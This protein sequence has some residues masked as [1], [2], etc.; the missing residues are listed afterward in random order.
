M[1]TLHA[2]PIKD[3]K[4]QVPSPSYGHL[5][6][7]TALS[8][9]ACGNLLAS[10]SK[11][12]TL[13]LWDL[14]GP[15]P[16]HRLVLKGELNPW[17]GDTTPWDSIALSPDGTMLAAASQKRGLTIWN[18]S[19]KGLRILAEHKCGDPKPPSQR[20]GVPAPPP[21]SIAFT[22]DS[23]T[24]FLANGANPVKIIDLSKPS[25]IAAELKSGQRF[26]YRKVAKPV[27]LPGQIEIPEIPPKPE[28]IQIGE[29]LNVY[30]LAVSPDGQT[31]ALGAPSEIEI[32]KRT[33][34]GW[35]RSTGFWNAPSYC[36]RSMAFVRTGNTLLVGSRCGNGEVRRFAVNGD[37]PV[38]LGETVVHKAPITS[39]A[40]SPNGRFLVA[41]DQGGRVVVWSANMAKKLHEWNFPGPVY[42][43]A[44]SPDGR[45]LAL[46]NGDGTAYIPRLAVPTEKE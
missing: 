17:G 14:D 40:A 11:D 28:T 44:F 30:T 25:S 16:H 15:R 7:V 36:I 18:V 43:V 33:E 21:I 19:P 13:R 1:N 8:F 31:L 42:C 9:G 6:D 37:K 45:H 32:W 26:I 34:E 39:V 12:A 3:G 27:L 22:P 38:Q 24:L 23:K 29:P 2:W 5:S 20:W 10:A 41:A 46:G 4:I 35:S